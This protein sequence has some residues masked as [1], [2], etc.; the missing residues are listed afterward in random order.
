M[1]IET[2]TAPRDDWERWNERLSLLTDPPEALVA[3]IA[4]DAGDGNVTGMNLWDSAEAVG[5]FFL[6]RVNP[7]LAELGEPSTK[8][9]R[10]G[11]PLAV[12]I[13]PAGP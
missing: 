4:W 9:K 7:T 8:P 13:R 11:Q 6:A 12:Y 10:H 3:S 5:D 1:F 2:I